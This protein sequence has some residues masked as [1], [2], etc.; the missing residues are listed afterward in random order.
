MAAE[1]DIAQ[2]RLTSVPGVKREDP[3]HACSRNALCLGEWLLKD[4]F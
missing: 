4:F 2:L 1:D 3:R